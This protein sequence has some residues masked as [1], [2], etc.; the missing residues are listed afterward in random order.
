[1][2]KSD[3]YV[4]LD[5]ECA[6]SNSGL[7]L[8]YRR[9]HRS[10]TAEQRVARDDEAVHATPATRTAD[11]STSIYN[12][13]SR[14][15]VSDVKE[16]HDDVEEQHVWHHACRVA[17]QYSAT[18]TTTI[19]LLHSCDNERTVLLLLLLVPIGDVSE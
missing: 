13:L 12:N 10:S 7:N 15:T 11:A 19:L 18:T 3:R 2:R 4:Y 17:A 16:A 1:M 5:R 9:S 6:C 14:L 8:T